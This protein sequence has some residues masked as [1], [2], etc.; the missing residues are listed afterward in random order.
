MPP[1]P[2]FGCGLAASCHIFKVTCEPRPF[3][4]F[5][6]VVWQSDLSLDLPLRGNVAFEKARRDIGGMW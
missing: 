6:C 2:Y 4:N 3:D 1:H 5:V